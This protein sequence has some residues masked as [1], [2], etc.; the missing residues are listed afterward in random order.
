[1]PQFDLVNRS[2]IAVRRNY[3]SLNNQLLNFDYFLDPINIENQLQN[4]NEVENEDNLDDLET[5]ND[6]SYIL[7]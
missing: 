6:V 1:M 4:E 5:D 3:P 2:L 7:L